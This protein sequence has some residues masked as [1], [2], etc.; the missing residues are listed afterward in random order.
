M[1][2]L[3]GGNKSEAIGLTSCSVIITMIER[4][5][6]MQWSTLVECTYLIAPYLRLT[7]E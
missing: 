7:F 4:I 2:L 1:T 5:G 3:L 6:C